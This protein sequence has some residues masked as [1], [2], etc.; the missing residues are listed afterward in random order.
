MAT[1]QIRIEGLREFTSDLRSVDRRLPREIRSLN[2]DAA[3]KVATEARKRA[4]RRTGRLAG[5]IRS[6]ATQRHAYVKTNLIYG[7]VIEFG[8]PGHNIEP[9]PYIYAAIGSTRDDVMEAYAE[10]LE[11]LMRRAFPD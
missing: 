3:D 4:P 6:G 10:G 5:S 9:Q 7:P 2:K 11:D 8:W 1:A